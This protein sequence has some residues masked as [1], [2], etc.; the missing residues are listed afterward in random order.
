MDDKLRPVRIANALAIVSGII[1]IG[2][3]LL[4]V[5]APEFITNLF[6]AMF[7]GLDISKIVVPL[8]LGRTII[9]TVEVIF[10]GWIF[11]YLYAKIYNSIN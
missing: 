3:A 8:S 11:G 7:H 9:G 6:G 2:C 4:L 1:S 10:L 5:I